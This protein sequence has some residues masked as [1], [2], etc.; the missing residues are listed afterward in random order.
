[1][2]A[3]FSILSNDPV[4]G[5]APFTATG[6]GIALSV[7]A[8]LQV[9]RGFVR[10]WIARMDYAR[11][12]AAV[13]LSA[14]QSAVTFRLMRKAGS[15]TY[16]GIKLFTWDDT[17]AGQWTYTDTFLES[18]VSYAYRIEALDCRGFVIYTSQGLDLGPSPQRQKL[19]KGPLRR[20]VKR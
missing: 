3:V 2:S 14:P 12:N 7:S 5:S 8:Q 9:E 11:I 10:A 17:V 15:A 6:R 13:T 19:E 1:V 20:I 18:N 4:N 16:R